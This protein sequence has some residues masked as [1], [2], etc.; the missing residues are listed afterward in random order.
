MM[1]SARENELMIASD[2]LTSSNRTIKD[3][4][5]SSKSGSSLEIVSFWTLMGRMTAAMP[6]RRRTFKMLLPIT[7]PIKMSV[8]PLIMDEKETASS[9]APVPKAIMVRP[10]KSLLTLKFEATLDAPS[11]SQSA[12]L[13]RRTKPTMSNVICSAISIFVILFLMILYHALGYM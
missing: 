7:L 13:I 5:M 3:V 8:L 1:A 11:T 10:I 12:P 4:E 2:K 6:M 9:G